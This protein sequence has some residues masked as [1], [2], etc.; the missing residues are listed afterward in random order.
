MKQ[1]TKNQIIETC[2]KLYE[3]IE[4][5]SDL[6]VFDKIIYE[7]KKKDIEISVVTLKRYKKQGNWIRKIGNKKSENN[8]KKYQKKEKIDTKIDT[9]K[10]YQNE[11]KD[12]RIEISK[13]IINLYLQGE[14]TIFDCC[15][16][17]GVNYF[18]FFFW[19]NNISEISAM[20]A[21]A[22]KAMREIDIEALTERTRHYFRNKMVKNTVRKTVIISE[23][24]E[25][26]N[27][28]TGQTE[29]KNI[30]KRHI[31]TVQEISP[32]EYLHLL[33]TFEEKVQSEN[34]LSSDKKKTVDEMTI[35]E[36]E[37]EIKRLEGEDWNDEMP[38]YD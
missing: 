20:Y 23:V 22:K 36:L 1:W 26:T 7:L 37:S 6:D 35:K 24:K 21:E 33:K 11:K 16:A 19:T 31:Q 18:T 14:K 8:T 10:K 15:Q 30:P 32:T 29:I 5:K 13:S 17:F 4:G 2:K 28:K 38:D 12:Q 34:Q 9:E 27:E 3:T 25:V